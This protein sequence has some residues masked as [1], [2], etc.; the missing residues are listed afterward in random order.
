MADKVYCLMLSI[1]LAL[2]IVTPA[3]EYGR[4]AD[5][6]RQCR[7][8]RVLADDLKSLNSEDAPRNFIGVNISDTFFYR[9][10]M[11]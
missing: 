7:T 10:I 9:Y 11:R 3:V 1:T 6:I 8:V 2:G 4:A 5:A